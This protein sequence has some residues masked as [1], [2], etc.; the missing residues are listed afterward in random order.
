MSDFGVE[1]PPE[2]DVP[3]GG[4]VGMTHIIDCVTNHRSKW[5]TGDYGFVLAHS[6][7]L[8]LVLWK[9][10]LGLRDA[11]AELLAKLKI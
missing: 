8:P 6:R 5:F 11:P 2:K 1:I 9:G 7:P 10:Q 3:V 4:V